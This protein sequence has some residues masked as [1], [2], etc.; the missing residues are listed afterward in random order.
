M[1]GRCY[2]Y[3]LISTFS[4]YCGLPSPAPE[5]LPAATHVANEV[6]CLSKHHELS[7]KDVDRVINLII[8]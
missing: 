5:N 1:L 7:Q 3:P 8:K 6:I 4:T 2:F